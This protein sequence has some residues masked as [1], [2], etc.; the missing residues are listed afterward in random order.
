MSFLMG[1][2]LGTTG[3]KVILYDTNKK[4]IYRSYEEYSLSTPRAEWVEQDPGVWWDA[5]KKSIKRA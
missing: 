3:C 1:I 5:T 2:D 4:N